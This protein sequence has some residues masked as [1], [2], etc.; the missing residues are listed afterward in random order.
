MALTATG[1]GSGLD[2]E[3]LVTKL[4]EAERAPKQQRL[5]SREAAVTSS[6]SGLGSLKGALS[7]L[8]TSLDSAN[9][10]G[11]FD[12]RNGS[13][14]DSA[15]VAVS[16]S[17]SA[18]LGNYTATV[19]G[20]ATAQSL[21]VRD[22]FSSTDE[23]VG[24]GTLTLTLG[25]T[26]YT[27]DASDSNND[28]YG[29]FTAKA[30]VASTAITIDSTNNTLAGVRDAI[31]QADAGVTAA[32]VKS[33]DAYRLLISSDGTGAENSVQISV[34]DSGDGND[35]NNS[36]LSRL[37]FNAQA[38]TGSVYQTVAAADAT[39]TLNGL[40]LSSSSN[41]ITSV[42]D[43][44]TITLKSTTSSPVNLTVTDNKAGVKS[45]LNTFV[46][47]YNSY[48]NT[49]DELTGYDFALKKGGA[50]QGD[51]S[52]LSTSS[53]LR[54]TLG[55]AVSGYTGTNTRLA[56]IGVVTLSSGKLSIDDTKLEAA[57][58]S[59]FENVAAVVTRYG[60]VSQ[61]TGVSDVAFTSAVA[62]GAYNVA[63]SSMATNGSVLGS[64]LSVPLT[65]NSN[66]DTFSITIDGTASGTIALSNQQYTSISSLVSE[67]QTK[68]NA[69]TSLRSAGKGATVSSIDGKL[70]IS[71]NTPGSSSTV[72]LTNGTGDSTLTA[73]GL[74][75]A[76]AAAGTDLVGTI[77]GVSGVASGNV[78]SGAA[79]S[80]AVGLS[81]AISST[82]GGTVS[83]SQGV[84]DQL[85]EL[86][87]SLLGT[88]AALNSRM[89]SL[90]TSI[91]GIEDERKALE[92][93]LAKTEAR[94]RRQFNSLD[95][96]VNQLTS[97]GSFVAA[98]L[99]NIPVPGKST[100]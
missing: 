25:T 63:V 6:I 34:T 54:R 31:N 97:T 62:V 70:K 5:V 30:G 61:G 10:L 95:G 2:I 37:A 91:T 57:L 50:L 12:Q 83:I 42:V 41:T 85:D 28:T 71:S 80:D 73:L 88:D 53:Q 76:S 65:I 100:K 40:G 75:G 1:I 7:G 92:V 47:G 15:S 90:E 59:D 67:L 21:A 52:A 84:I 13:S 44:L 82:T 64:A 60:S 38:G 56:E 19:Q 78:L 89:N 99:A 29:G 68:I 49:L 79:G 86:L 43:G 18:F 58:T 46:A 35:T 16:A 33:G 77:N 20:L 98:Q 81:M 69:D 87:T 32:I 8:Q 72:T 55:A 9:S 24:T 4:M 74:N 22:T 94:F 23:A 17:S 39:F 48:I 3:S 36:G 26:S 11:T 96:L 51:F 14:S 66:N 93:R 45:A 27:A